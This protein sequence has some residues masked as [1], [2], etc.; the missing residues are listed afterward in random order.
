MQGGRACLVSRFGIR[1]D[2]FWFIKIMVCR[3]DQDVIKLVESWLLEA[4]K[5]YSDAQI[6]QSVR[7]WTELE[8]CF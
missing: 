7:K 5:A 3:I 2:R 1:D 8:V 6:G 4:L